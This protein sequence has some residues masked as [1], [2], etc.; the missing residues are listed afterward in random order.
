MFFK[1][2]ISIPINDMKN[3]DKYQEKYFA[4]PECYRAVEMDSSDYIY[5]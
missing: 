3:I 1:Y 4:Y 5:T 2:T